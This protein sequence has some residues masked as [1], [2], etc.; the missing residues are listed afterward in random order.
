AC[1]RESAPSIRADLAGDTGRPAESGAAAGDSKLEDASPRG[2]F[3]VPE[4]A[5]KS[6]VSV[7][8]SNAGI[9]AIDG[10]GHRTLITDF[11]DDRDPTLSRDHTMVAFVRPLTSVLD[12]QAVEGPAWRTEIWIARERE[13]P[14]RLLAGRSTLPGIGNL[15]F[16]PDGRTIYFQW[17]CSVTSP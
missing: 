6:A 2:D 3:A 10:T 7:E 5:L 14:K 11:T 15:E 9:V 16:S 13:V 17:S 4:G 1:R 8:D 12:E